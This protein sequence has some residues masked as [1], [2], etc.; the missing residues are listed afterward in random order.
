MQYH[1]VLLPD[2][3]TIH[4][5]GGPVFSTSTASTI[6]GREIR[7]CERQNAFQKYV[8]VGC[9]LSQ[10]EFSRFNSFFRA[11]LGCAYAFRIRDHADFKIANQVIAIG[12]GLKRE[13]GIYKSYEDDACD[14]KRKISSIRDGSIVANHPFESVDRINGVLHMQEIVE[15]GAELVIS[16]EFDVW[17]RFVSDEFRYSSELDGSI[18]IED[19]E[20][21]EVI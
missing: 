13:F 2:F 12:D 8:L 16:A 15:E 17:V 3:L 9:R 4:L 6:S 19:L 11:R 18:L 1:D 14:Y 20:L 5:K 7:V 21:V 10:D